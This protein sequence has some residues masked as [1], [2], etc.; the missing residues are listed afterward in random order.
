MIHFAQAVRG[1]SDLGR[2]MI[3]QMGEALESAQPEAF[4]EAMF[5]L[6]A[7]LISSKGVVFFP[8]LSLLW[9]YMFWLGIKRRAVCPPE[10]DPQLLHHLCWSPLKMFTAHGME[11]AIA[12]WEWLLAARGGVEVPV[13][14]Y[15]FG[16]FFF[17]F[18]P[19]LCLIL[20]FVP[21]AHV[22]DFCLSSSCERWLERGKWLWSWRWAC[23]RTLRW[24]LI[25]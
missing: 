14:K 1:Q 20:C 15:I 24:R 7:L 13:R 17:S 10:C 23:S 21:S 5:K 11:T 18:K 6:A 19:F 22:I 25:L 8:K 4:T 12:C 2:L 16:F 9:T 3:K